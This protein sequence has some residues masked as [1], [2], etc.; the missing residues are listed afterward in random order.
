[1]C[2]FVW[3]DAP[4]IQPQKAGEVSRQIDQGMGIPFRSLGVSGQGSAFMFGRH[5]CACGF[6]GGDL[7]ARRSF[8][9]LN[10]ERAADMERAFEII[11]EHSE[12][13]EFSVYA[14]WQD[15]GPRQEFGKPIRI[16]FDRLQRELAE[17]RVVKHRRL[18]VGKG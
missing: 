14:E 10:P 15:N 6:L 4:H 1:M 7:D 12:G 8:F 3:V 17:N 9:R 13:R 18:L 11:R 5:Q 2:F 16:S